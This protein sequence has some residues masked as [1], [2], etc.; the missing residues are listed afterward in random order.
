MCHNIGN[1]ISPVKKNLKN[2]MKFPGLQ[3]I[4]IR[5]KLYLFSF[6][7]TFRCSLQT[8]M[9][10]IE[11]HKYKYLKKKYFCYVIF[12][13]TSVANIK[14]IISYSTP[15]IGLFKSYEGN[16]GHTRVLMVL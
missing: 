12:G 9:V 16:G 1:N 2:F 4:H 7:S 13:F 5:I 15:S 14:F 10:L 11:S 8:K 3:L 6:R